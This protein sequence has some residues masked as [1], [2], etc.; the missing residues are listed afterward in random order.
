MKKIL[1]GILI[2]YCLISLI[3]SYCEDEDGEETV[4]IRHSKDCTSR[5]ISEAEQNEGGYRCCYM[6][7]KVDLLTYKGKIYSCVLLNQNEYNDI[8]NVIK[9]REKENGIKDV[10]IDCKSS[11]LYNGLLIVFALLL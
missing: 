10:K 4:R 2:I 6:R 9:N 3:N 1:Y 8:K 5:I 11:Y 7:E